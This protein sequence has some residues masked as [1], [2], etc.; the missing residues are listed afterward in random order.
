M[1]SGDL[2]LDL[3]A[4]DDLL[5]FLVYV[6]I[7]MKRTSNASLAIEAD[8]LTLVISSDDWNAWLATMRTAV[9]SVTVQV[10]DPRDP[11]KVLHT[12]VDVRWPTRWARD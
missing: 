2:D 7:A 1:P 3:V 9:A 5:V 12:I 11:G 10:E 6:G 8:K 4:N